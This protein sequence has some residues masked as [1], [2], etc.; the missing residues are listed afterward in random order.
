M[1]H[2]AAGST[3]TRIGLV[4]ELPTHRLKFVTAD[5]VFTRVRC[6]DGPQ[7]MR[8]RF[9]IPEEERHKYML[10][11]E[12]TTPAA[13]REEDRHCVG[14]AVTSSVSYTRCVLPARSLTRRHPSPSSFLDRRQVLEEYCRALVAKGRIPVPALLRQSF[15]RGNQGLRMLNLANQGLGNDFV[16]SLREVRT[17][18]RGWEIPFFG[19]SLG[20]MPRSQRKHN[21]SIQPQAITITVTSEREERVT[22]RAPF[23]A[24]VIPPFAVARHDARRSAPPSSLFRRRPTDLTRTVP[25]RRPPSFRRRTTDTMRALF[26][27]AVSPRSAPPPHRPRPLAVVDRGAAADGAP[28]GDQ[29]VRQP[30][31]RRGARRRDPRGERHAAARVR[32]TP[33]AAGLTA[34]PVHM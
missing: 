29:H 9:S 17:R 13:V 19:D 18:A 32:R 22:R 10:D 25:R 33:R 12:S 4:A 34:R 27:A 2:L 20:M 6:D 8:Q 23:C 21:R 14:R 26:R 24:A 3:H 30:A 1:F 7:V 5:F 15:R 16:I 11:T 31:D 28:R